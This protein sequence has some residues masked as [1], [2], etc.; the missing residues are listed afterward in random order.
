MR[1]VEGGREKVV[2]V[3]DLVEYLQPRHGL[4]KRCVH[5]TVISEYI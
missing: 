5:D 1:S 4:E 2:G 3:T